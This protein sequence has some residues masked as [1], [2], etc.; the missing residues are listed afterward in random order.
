MFFLSTRLTF[1]IMLRIWDERR[2]H[3]KFM[4]ILRMTFKAKHKKSFLIRKNAKYRLRSASILEIFAEFQGKGKFLLWFCSGSFLHILLLWI[5][6]VS[7]VARTKI[8]EIPL[9]FINVK[10]KDFSLCSNKQPRSKRK[11]RNLCKWNLWA[12]QK[13]SL[14]SRI[15]Q[16]FPL[17]W[18]HLFIWLDV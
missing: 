4:I 3:E 2:V 16:N 15:C 1:D 12:K 5:P 17:M 8:A 18:S 9:L 7:D 11:L 10:E 13:K 14:K 6:S